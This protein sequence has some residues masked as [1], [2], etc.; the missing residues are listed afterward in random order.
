M[1]TMAKRRLKRNESSKQSRLGV[2]AGVAAVVVAAVVITVAIRTSGP[3]LE[4]RARYPGPAGGNYHF[5]RNTVE[6]RSAEKLGVALYTQSA[7][8]WHEAGVSLGMRNPMGWF[9]RPLLIPAKGIASCERR[10][11]NGLWTGIE[12]WVADPGIGIGFPGYDE[13]SVLAWCRE[14]G[15]RV[16]EDKSAAQ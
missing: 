11:M 15:I 7:T 4:L 16:L 6:L 8:E 3:W 12:L 5:G 10:K 9:L 13:K 1:H 2:Q 14:R